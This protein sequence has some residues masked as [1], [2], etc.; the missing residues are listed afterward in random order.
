MLKPQPALHKWS[1]EIDQLKIPLHHT[2]LARLPVNGDI[3]IVEQDEFVVQTEREIVLVYGSRCPIVK[4]NVPV[5]PFYINY[6]YIIPLFV[7]KEYN[8]CAERRETSCSE[9][10]PPQ[11]MA[12]V[13][14]VLFMCL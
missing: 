8:P 6:V 9:E 7:E 2:I 4:I 10:S 5:S 1:K 3:G 14:F 12:I 11:T 13:R